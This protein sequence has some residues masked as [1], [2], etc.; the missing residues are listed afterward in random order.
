MCEICQDEDDNKWLDI[1]YEAKAQ[2][3]LT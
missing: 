2:V 1:A 3:I